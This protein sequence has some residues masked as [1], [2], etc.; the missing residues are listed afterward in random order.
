MGWNNLGMHCMD[1]DYSVLSILPPYNTIEAQIVWGLNGTAHLVKNGTGYAVSYAD[2]ADSAGSV[3][4][5]AV[6][7]GNFW[8]YV[9]LLLGQALPPDAGVDLS[10]AGYSQSYMPGTNNAP[11]R[12]TYEAGYGWFA[13]YGVPI[14]PYDDLMRKNAYP[15]MRLSASNGNTRVA[16]ADIVLP[17][18]DE[19]DCAFVTPPAPVRRPCRLPAG[20]GIRTRHA[21][22]AST[23]CAFTMRSGIKKCRPSTPSFSLRKGS[24][25]TACIPLWSSTA[26]R[27]SALPAT[28]PKPCRARGMP[29]FRL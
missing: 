10:A 17:V 8:T 28:F 18:S 29:A 7:K 14:T 26:N 24:R 2:V 1:N 4:T 16:M 3:N 9:P 25:R 5:T 11:K 15:M 27:S 21:T 22:I 20:C 19:M 23:S 13:A 12:M 6:G